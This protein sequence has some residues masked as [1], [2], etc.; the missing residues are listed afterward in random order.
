MNQ[1]LFRDFRIKEWTIYTIFIYFVPFLSISNVLK[2]LIV[3]LTDVRRQH[4]YKW[5][6]NLCSL[7]TEEI[8]V[9]VTL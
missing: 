4:K 1:N 5:N 3:F 7:F 9:R 2:K 8:A 6:D